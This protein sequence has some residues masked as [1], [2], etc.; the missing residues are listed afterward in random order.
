MTDKIIH[1]TTDGHGT[2]YTELEMPEEHKKYLDDMNHNV[3]LIC[4]AFGV[5]IE[6]MKPLLTVVP[7]ITIGRLRLNKVITYNGS[8]VNGYKKQIR[9]RIMWLP[10][11]GP[12]PIEKCMP[13]I[14]NMLWLKKYFNGNY[15]R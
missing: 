6:I 3:E 4:Q 1:M 2:P 13:T 8:V 14:L 12:S 7:L 15:R 11:F 9:Y 5:P 10:K